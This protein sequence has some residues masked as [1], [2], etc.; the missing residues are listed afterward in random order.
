MRGHQTREQF[1]GVSGECEASP[2]GGGH[3]RLYAKRFVGNGTN[4]QPMICDGV[5]RSSEYLA[6]PV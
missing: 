4:F 5:V 3:M 6:V 2:N 1:G